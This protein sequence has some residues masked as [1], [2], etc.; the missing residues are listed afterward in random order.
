MEI[1]AIGLPSILIPASGRPIAI[2]CIGAME[3][4]YGRLSHKSLQGHKIHY[5]RDR[6]PDGAVIATNTPVSRIGWNVIGSR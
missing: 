6:R 4:R 1:T 5:I 2:A 3:Q